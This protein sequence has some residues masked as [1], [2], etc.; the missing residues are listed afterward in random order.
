MVKNDLIVIGAGTGGYVAACGAL[1]LGLRNVVLID[2]NDQIG[3]TGLHTGCVPSKMLMHIAKTANNIRQ[4]T[5]YGLDSYLLDVDFAK[6]AQYIKNQ[7]ADLALRETQEAQNIFRQLGGKFIQG[8]AQFIDNHTI[9]IVDQIL[10]AKHIVL[11]TGSRPIYPEIKDIDQIGYFTNESIFNLKKLPKQLAILGNEAEAVEF[12]QAFALLGSKVFLLVDT[13]H[14]LPNEDQELVD[15]LQHLIKQY[16]IEIY[17]STKVNSIYTYKGQNILE[18]THAGGETFALAV[19]AILTA[20]GRRP[21]IEELAL[22]KSGIA[23]SA[24][25]IMVNDQMQTTQKNIYA[26][27]DVTATPYKLTHAAEYQAN[28]VLSHI[29]LKQNNHAD[30]LGFPY[31]IFTDPEYAQVGLQEQ[32]AYAQD[33]DGIAVTRFDFKDLD[34]AYLKNAQHGR[35]KIITRNDKIIGASILGVEAGNL[36]AEWCLAIKMQANIADVA[37]TVHAYPSMAQI[38]RRVANKYIRKIA[39]GRRK[40]AKWTQRILS[41]A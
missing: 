4:A 13:E 21:N 10:S 14:I 24:H 29:L 15:Q 22:E 31:V 8:K 5:Q 33:L 30:Y 6:I 19:D 37:T 41:W 35:I 7:V 9:Q 12:A 26:V 20:S 36:L 3:G 18:C 40:I 11:A 32:Q 39:H 16:G 38:N 25:G 28:I 2:K 34:G 23:Y 27:G 1:R 17:V